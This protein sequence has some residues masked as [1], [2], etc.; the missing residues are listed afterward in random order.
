[1]H[2]LAMVSVYFCVHLVYMLETCSKL[3]LIYG[4][5]DSIVLC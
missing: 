3:M 5:Q 1:M 4:L 2:F